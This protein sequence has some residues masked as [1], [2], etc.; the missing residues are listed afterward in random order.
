MALPESP[1]PGRP[2]ARGAS[3][4]ACILVGRNRA[5]AFSPQASLGQACCVPSSRT[6]PGRG[7]HDRLPV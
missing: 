3:S 7:R 2:H 5:Q 6:C 1:H 4:Q